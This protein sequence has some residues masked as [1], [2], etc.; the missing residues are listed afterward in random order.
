MARKTDTSG[1]LL[2]GLRSMLGGKPTKAVAETAP[3]PITLSPDPAGHFQTPD[4]PDTPAP[5]PA[6]E[7]DQSKP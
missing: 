4:T 3:E 2:G 7:Q 5:P 1:G 6:P